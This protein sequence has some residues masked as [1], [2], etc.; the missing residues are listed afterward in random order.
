[1]A[2]A[3]DTARLNS[4]EHALE[5]IGPNGPTTQTSMAIRVLIAYI[6][7]RLGLPVPELN[8]DLPEFYRLDTSLCLVREQ[9]EGGYVLRDHAQRLLLPREAPQP[10]NALRAHNEILPD[11]RERSCGKG[12]GLK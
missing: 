3:I 12:G 10:H 7:R 8:E 11:R 4:Q 6:N 2:T 9:L 5:A 1:M